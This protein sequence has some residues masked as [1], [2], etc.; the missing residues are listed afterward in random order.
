[1]RVA[2]VDGRERW[3]LA[4]LEHQAKAELG[5]VEVDGGIQVAHEQAGMVVFAIDFRHCHGAYPMLAAVVQQQRIRE[6]SMFGRERSA[7][8]Y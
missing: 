5:C 1:L 4:P 7:C 6:R 8:V 2:Q 3:R